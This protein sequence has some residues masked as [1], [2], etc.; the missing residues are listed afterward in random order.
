MS[1]RAGTATL[2]VV[3]HPRTWPGAC[4]TCLPHSSHVAH[5][6]GAEEQEE[7]GRGLDR[8]P[9]LFCLSN[10]RGR[11]QTAAAILRRPNRG[12]EHQ[13]RDDLPPDWWIADVVIIY[14]MAV[15]RRGQKDVL[16][17]RRNQSQRR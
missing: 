6:H 17:R 4:L 16:S 10:R 5:R 13:N 2:V 9:I 15:V 14:N 3:A 12:I 7:V 8:L 1:D 11:R